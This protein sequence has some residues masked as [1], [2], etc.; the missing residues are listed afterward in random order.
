M[1]RSLGLDA[2][3][4]C[5]MNINEPLGSTW[6]V[7]A[8]PKMRNRKLDPGENPKDVDVNYAPDFFH[9]GNKAQGFDGIAT[10]YCHQNGG[11][12]IPT[13]HRISLT[14]CAVYQYSVEQT[15]QTGQTGHKVTR[16][17]DKLHVMFFVPSSKPNCSEHGRMVHDAFTFQDLN[18][19]VGQHV[20]S[21]F[22]H[23]KVRF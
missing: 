6:A 10:E 14:G 18:H 3:N 9:P 5:S 17:Q 1:V 15:G 20:S 23:S 19:F 11:N 8:Q 22:I 2:W 16:S 21:Y 12:C 7:D 13:A 4:I